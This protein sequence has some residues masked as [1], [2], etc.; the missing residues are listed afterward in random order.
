MLQKVTG[1]RLKYKQ[2]VKNKFPQAVC[3]KYSYARTSTISGY[4][5]K[6]AMKELSGFKHSAEKAWEDAWFK[7]IDAPLS[8][9]FTCQHC[10]ERFR[11]ELDLDSHQFNNKYCP[12]E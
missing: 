12:S 6:T 2:A 3:K 7:I 4:V 9:E 10:A 5:V 11:S 1:E 8:S